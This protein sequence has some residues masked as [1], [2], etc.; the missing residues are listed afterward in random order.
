VTLC[1][2]KFN[3]LRRIAML[4]RAADALPAALGQHAHSMAQRPRPGIAVTSH[5]GVMLAGISAFR[6]ASMETGRAAGSRSL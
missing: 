3:G 4:T 6:L 2:R 5:Q 1:R